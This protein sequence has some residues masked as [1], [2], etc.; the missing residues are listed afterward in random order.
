MWLEEL[1]FAL[2]EFLDKG[3]VVLW[4]IL[5]LSFYLFALIFERL[6]YLFFSAKEYEAGLVEALHQHSVFFELVRLEYLAKKQFFK[7]QNLI[8]ITI[9][10]MP[11]MGLLGTV[12][13]MIEVF[14]VMALFGNSNPRLMASGVA[15]AIIPTMTGMAVAVLSIF[16]LYILRVFAIK[17]MNKTI[18]NLKE[19][20]NATL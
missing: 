17:Q 2:F 14:E 16:A 15:K 9:A 6:I 5:G 18:K 4:A 12:T 1:W 10:M 8:T 7:R 11:L 3:G 19:V 20:Y 13:G